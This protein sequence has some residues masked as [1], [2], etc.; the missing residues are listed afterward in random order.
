MDLQK[1]HESKNE[2]GTNRETFLSLK[3]DGLTKSK[4]LTAMLETESI[5]FASESLEINSSSA[6]RIPSVYFGRAD[7]HRLTAVLHS[8]SH[9]WVVIL[10]KGRA[11]LSDNMDFLFT[12]HKIRKSRKTF[13]D[14]RSDLQPGRDPSSN[15]L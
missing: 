6:L 12:S 5:L 4:P 10:R 2:R 11:Q 9:I 3:R 1:A 7:F 8:P 14:A 15:A 13:F